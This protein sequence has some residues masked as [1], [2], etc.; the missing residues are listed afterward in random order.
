MA[1]E[2][3]PLRGDWIKPAAGY[4]SYP[5]ARP[6]FCAARRV[7]PHCELVS[8]TTSPRCPVCD[9]RFSPSLLARIL[10]RRST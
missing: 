9:A 2:P 7:C 4:H 8:Q 1:F 6:R 10:R 3:P 5:P